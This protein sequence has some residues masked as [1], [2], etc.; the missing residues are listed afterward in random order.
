M[1]LEVFNL[2]EQLND[3]SE[4]LG[5]HIG[6]LI[7]LLIA[8]FFSYVDDNYNLMYAFGGGSIVPLVFTF[9]FYL[10][11]EKLKERIINE[12]SK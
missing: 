9:I 5:W 11:R 3:S 2:L 1:R 8:I 12:V 4:N 10:E 7:G 6:L